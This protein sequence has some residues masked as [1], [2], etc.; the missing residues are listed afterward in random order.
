MPFRTLRVLLRR[1]ASRTA[2]PR[3][4]V[5]NDNSTTV[6]RSASTCLSR[7][8]ERSSQ[9]SCDAL[10][11]MPFRTL[12][13]LLRRGASR[14]AFPRWSVGNDHLNCRTALCVDISIR[15]CGTIIAIIVRRSASHAFPDAL[16]PLATRSVE[17][18][19]P[20]W[21]VGN[22]HLNCRTALCVDISIRTCGTIIAIIVRRSASRTALPR[23]SVRNDNSTNV[24]RSASTL[25]ARRY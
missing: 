7:R 21:S 10:R 9:L 11:R 20:R 2:F 6:R 23:W 15:T 12:C 1:R 17:N 3:W 18:C 19:I 16:R 8:A 24:R 22:D 25:Y 13:V 4:S 5:R 14:T